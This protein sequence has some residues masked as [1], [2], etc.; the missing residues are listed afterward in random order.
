MAPTLSGV[1]ALDPLGALKLLGFAE[2]VLG[3]QLIVG[4]FTRVSAILS[5]IGL[6]I[7]ILHIGLD[8]I[9]IRDAGLV[10]T[11]A[12]LWATGGGAYSLDRWLE[13]PA[14][15]ISRSEA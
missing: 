11:A 8:Q 10:A 6:V 5:G 4:L 15:A 9:G 2:A 3:V 7:V 1:E 12:A 13:R 14:Q